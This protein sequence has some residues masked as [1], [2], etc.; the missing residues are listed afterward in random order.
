MS[1]SS[2]AHIPSY[3]SSPGRYVVT[4]RRAGGEL[5]LVPDTSAE[6]IR[7]APYGA[8]HSCTPTPVFSP[9]MP[10]SRT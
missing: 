8:T 4:D 3:R 6:A 1:F 7:E 5:T 10:L 9:S 2:A